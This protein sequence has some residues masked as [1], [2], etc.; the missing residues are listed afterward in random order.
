MGG[1]A[2]GV[3]V[4]EGM[5]RSDPAH[6]DNMQARLRFMSAQAAAD[7]KYDPVPPPRVDA[8]IVGGSSA[9]GDSGSGSGSGRRRVAVVLGGAFLL[10]LGAAWWLRRRRGG[11]RV[12]AA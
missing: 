12:C 4:P 11:G 6:P 1:A 8:F 2:D 3:G 7:T 5:A 10:M 9:H